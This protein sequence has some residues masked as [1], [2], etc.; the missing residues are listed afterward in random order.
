MWVSSNTNIYTLDRNLTNVL[1]AATHFQASVI[2]WPITFFTF[3]QSQSTQVHTL[4]RNL[5]NPLSNNSER[6]EKLGH[7]KVQILQI[8]SHNWMKLVLTKG[9]WLEFIYIRTKLINQHC[10]PKILLLKKNIDN[11]D[12]HVKSQYRIDCF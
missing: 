6:T 2:L 12:L 5:K 9:M 11:T 7:S 10:C 3:L 4:L 8:S 1:S